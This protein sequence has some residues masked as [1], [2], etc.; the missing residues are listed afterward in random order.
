MKTP[1]ILNLGCLLLAACLTLPFLSHAQST[2]N[3][4]VYDFTTVAGTP[5]VSGNS[6]GTNGQ[7]Q[8]NLPT[9]VK[10]DQNG[11]L[12]VADYYNATIRKITLSSTNWVVTTIA[13]Q[14]GIMG[15]V[16][17]TNDTSRFE[18]PWDL[19]VDNN[20]TIY[21]TD[22]Y[23]SN[24]YVNRIRKITPAG[25][26]WVVTT[27]ATNVAINGIATAGGNLYMTTQGA[28]LRLSPIGTNWTT[29]S[30]AGY[31]GV[32][33]RNGTNG[34]ALFNDPEG[35]AADSSGNLYVADSQND[36]IRK[37]TAVGTN[38]VASTVAGSP[39]SSV[40]IHPTDVA[41]DGA[42]NVFVDGPINT[43]LKIVPSGTNWVVSTIGGVPGQTG[44]SNGLSSA[45][46]FNGPG[47]LVVDAT[48]D[49]YVADLENNTIR[50]GRPLT[51]PALTGLSTT[52]GTLGM[53]WSANAGAAYQLE[54]TTC[55]NGSNW[56]NL[57][58]PAT[59]TNSTLTLFDTPGNTTNRFYRL[60][61]LP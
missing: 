58:D 10:L 40:F 60:I 35:I 42:G 29:T 31:L 43:I 49:V 59:A 37:L 47:G 39:G 52:T 1:R 33:F 14:A 48:G 16:D 36:M 28:I 7:A 18:A 27:I 24:P 23:G 5:L 2:P 38:W 34:L 4:L 19:A 22:D 54:Y 11:N 61:L 12:Y 50:Q 53:T 30:I 56:I 46:M 13:G 3:Q 55:L 45:A 6:D 9:A 21:V 25:T 44:H 26:N 51:I 41:V 17:G 8:F 15:F 57:G 32:G 20:G